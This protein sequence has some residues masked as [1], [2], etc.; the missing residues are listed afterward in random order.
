MHELFNK[1][2]RWSRSRAK[3]TAPAP[4][5]YPG[6][7]R[8]RLRNPA[9][10]CNFSFSLIFIISQFFSL[11]RSGSSDGH[12]LLDFTNQRLEISTNGSTARGAELWRTMDDLPIDWS[13][14][15]RARFTSAQAWSWG[16]HLSTVEAASG[17][18]GGVR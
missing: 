1:Y 17:L 11:V 18:T 5:K 13:L 6:S 15:S 9:G 3:V 14:K 16:Q 10:I 2:L 4:A 7:G 8:L 12:P